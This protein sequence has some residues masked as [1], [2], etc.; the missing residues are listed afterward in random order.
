MDQAVLKIKCTCKKKYILK[1]INPL[2]FGM[3]NESEKRIIHEK[4]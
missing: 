3:L 4:I 1:D 2:E